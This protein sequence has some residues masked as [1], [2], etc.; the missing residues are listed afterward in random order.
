MVMVG[1]VERIKEEESSYLPGKKQET[2]L[3]SREEN[4]FDVYLGDILKLMSPWIVERRKKQ[5]RIA[6]LTVSYLFLYHSA[7]QHTWHC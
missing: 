5:S 6:L 3:K 7:Q 4:R 1:G 2:R